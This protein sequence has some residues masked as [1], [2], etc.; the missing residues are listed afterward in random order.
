[1]AFN[2]ALGASLHVVQAMSMMAEMAI[3]THGTP[4]SDCDGCSNPQMDGA[5]CKA[6]D[7]RAELRQ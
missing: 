1:M 4:H 5:G 7:M 6:G 3:S 2:L